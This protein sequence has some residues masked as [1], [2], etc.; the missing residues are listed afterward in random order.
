MVKLQSAGWG[1]GIPPG[2]RRRPAGVQGRGL[3]V[4]DYDVRERD[5]RVPA[6]ILT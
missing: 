6:W 4:S 2:P 1:P 5:P 3:F